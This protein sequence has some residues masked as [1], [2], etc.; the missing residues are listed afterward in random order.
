MGLYATIAPCF[1]AFPH[2]LLECI[3]LAY[4]AKTVPKM[5]ERATLQ[6]LCQF[7]NWSQ[8]DK[9]CHNVTKR[10]CLTKNKQQACQGIF[11]KNPIKSDTYDYFPTFSHFGTRPALCLLPSQE[12]AKAKT[13]LSS[14][15][16]YQKMNIS[17]LLKGAKFFKENKKLVQDEA[18][19]LSTVPGIHGS[20]VTQL[21]ALSNATHGGSSNTGMSQAGW[22]PLA[23]VVG[24]VSPSSTKLKDNTPANKQLVL[25]NF[26][27]TGQYPSTR[28]GGKGGGRADYSVEG[29]SKQIREGVWSQDNNARILQQDIVTIE[30]PLSLAESLKLA[31]DYLEARQAAPTVK[32]ATRRTN[33]PAKG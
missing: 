6:K 29:V 16:E 19:M 25:E 1:Q 4:V 9:N 21:V 23:E 33:K 22:A 31:Q 10:G 28:K 24:M 8:F 26:I 32:P 15:R 11:S 2:C 3:A 17:F 14:F 12:V 30:Q 5:G 18:K 20:V 13:N 27:R 7:Q